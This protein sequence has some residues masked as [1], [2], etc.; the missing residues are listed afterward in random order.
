MR[1]LTRFG[2]SRHS[3]LGCYALRS[4]EGCSTDFNGD[5]K[6]GQDTRTGTLVFVS[7]CDPFGTNSDGE[8]IFAMRP[9]G[10]GLH[11]L[12]DAHAVVQNADGSVE[13]ELPGQWSYGPHR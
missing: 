1:Q 10:S 6:V 12:T 3:G 4:S 13:A 7:T 2:A 9:D 8:Q 5:Q 11:A